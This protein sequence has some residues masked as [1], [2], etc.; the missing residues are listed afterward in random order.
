MNLQASIKM[1]MQSY[2]A[3]TRQLRFTV[4]VLAGAYCAAVI[5]L[6]PAAQP[7]TTIPASAS[8]KSVIDAKEP[9]VAAESIADKNAFQNH[10]IR[11]SGPELFYLRDKAGEA[12]GRAG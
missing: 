5:G 11:E 8:A 3:K 6:L 12:K 9:A 4:S 1:S 7:P 10:E 2:A